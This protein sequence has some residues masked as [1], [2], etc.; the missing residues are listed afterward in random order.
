MGLLVGIASFIVF[1][2][3]QAQGIFAGDSGDLVTAA[4]EFGVPH[5][6]GYPLYSFL[7]YLF[8]LVPIF[9]PSWRLTLLSSIPHAATVALIYSIVYLLTKSRLSAVFAGLTL[10]GNYLF[11]LYSV[12][13]EVFALFDMFLLLLVYEFIRYRETHSMRILSVMALTF[14]LSLTHHHVMVFAIPALLFGV[15]SVGLPKKFG[16][17]EILILALFFILGL[18]PYVYLPIAGSTTAIINWDKPTTVAR[19]IQLVTRQDYGSFL[20][21]GVIGKSLIERFISMKAYFSFLVLDFRV[22]GIILSFVGLFVL[23]MRERVLCKTVSLLLFILGPFFFFY[24]SFPIVGRFT[25]GTYER[26]LLPS[27]CIYALILGIGFDEVVR[28]VTLFGK[29]RWSGSPLFGI[30]FSVILFLYPIAMASITLYRFMGLSNDKTAENLGK[31]VLQSVP[32]Y[33]ILLLSQDTLLFITQYVRYGMKVRPDTIVLHA[34]RMTAEDYNEVVKNRFSN[35]VLPDIHSQTYLGDFIK[36]NKKDHRI[37]SNTILGVG[38]GWYFIP[39]GLLYEIVPFEELLPVSL[40][41]EVNS[42]LFATYNNP[43]TGILSRYKH[44]MLSDVLDVY[45]WSHIN[46]GKTLVKATAYEKAIVEFSQAVF[47]DGNS[48]KKDAYTYLGAT[49]SVTGRC[50]EALEALSKARDASFKVQPEQLLYESLTYRDCV[51]DA[52]KANALFSEYE[53]LKIS[54]D[55]PLQSL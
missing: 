8:S 10:L 11:F 30:V 48:S 35:L 6:P 43:L 12:T 46:Y 53:K 20:S 17:R 25:L 13:P 5:P 7:G 19:F 54:L 15:I 49:Y 51:K 44:L 41:Q 22:I 37:F 2:F 29:R 31:D 4:I 26:F 47:L 18:L 27:Y 36:A 52:T 39:H 14:G 33:A 23:W 42:E 1:L 16:V 38:T 34:S 3:F 32:Q 50:N 40:L 21:G 24:A 45:A 28:V 9:T 55:T